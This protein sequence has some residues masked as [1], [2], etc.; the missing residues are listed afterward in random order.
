MAK[1]YQGRTVH[2][3]RLAGGRD[4]GRDMGE[5]KDHGARRLRDFATTAQDRLH[6]GHDGHEQ[7][8]QEALLA[9]DRASIAYVYTLAIPGRE[10][11]FTVLDSVVQRLL[12]DGPTWL[13]RILDLQTDLTPEQFGEMSPLGAATLRQLRGL[14]QRLI[15]QA[16]PRTLHA[17]RRSDPEQLQA[18]RQAGARRPA[19]SHAKRPHIGLIGQHLTLPVKHVKLVRDSPR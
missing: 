9:Q 18:D 17:V 15:S 19:E 14:A 16:A 12:Y 7:P 4:T 2:W 1:E 13:S 5:R 11:A 10:V 8:R 3:H 6:H